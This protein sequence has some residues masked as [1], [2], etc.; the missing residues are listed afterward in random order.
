MHKHLC[1]VTIHISCISRMIFYFLF[2]GEQ[3]K[4]KIYLSVMIHVFVTSGLLIWVKNIK[5]YIEVLIV[6]THQ[7]HIFLTSKY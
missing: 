6:M 7:P 2:H 1:I 5:N 4:R 3:E